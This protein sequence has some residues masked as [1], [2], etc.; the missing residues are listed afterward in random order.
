MS[1]ACRQPRPIFTLVFLHMNS[2]WSDRER[3]SRKWEQGGATL[4]QDV[5]AEMRHSLLFKARSRREKGPP[6]QMML[7]KRVT[8]P[9][10]TAMLNK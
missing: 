9:G 1:S 10:V 4:Q 5:V 2:C 7:W 6:D 8:E 3:K